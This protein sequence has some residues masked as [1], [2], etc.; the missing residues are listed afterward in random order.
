MK[1]FQI[2]SLFLCTAALASATTITVVEH[3]SPVG[4]VFVA[5]DGETA[6]ITSDA[7]TPFSLT[8]NGGLV[9][10]IPNDPIA[11]IQFEGDSGGG[12]CIGDRGNLV[13]ASSQVVMDMCA[14]A[15]HVLPVGPLVPLAF[16]QGSFQICQADQTVSSAPAIVGLDH[17]SDTRLP[18][19]RESN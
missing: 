4:S 15:V 12:G 16:P 5:G 9:A 18:S 7:G 13:F 19:V 2:S 1:A 10:D 11:Y 17:D 8:S 14:F 3:H 6:T